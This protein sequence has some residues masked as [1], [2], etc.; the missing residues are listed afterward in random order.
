[1]QWHKGPQQQRPHCHPN[2]ETVPMD[3]D[4]V[5]AARRAVTAEDKKKHRNKGQCYNCSKQG[6]LARECPNKKRLQ[7]QP[8]G[9]PSLAN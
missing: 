8:S 4:T 2:D 9:K 5:M 7:M 1:M 6:H 3:V